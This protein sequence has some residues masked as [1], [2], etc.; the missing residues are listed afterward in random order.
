M[1]EKT[2]SSYGMLPRR[3]A[4]PDPQDLSAPIVVGEKSAPKNS[5][6]FDLELLDQQLAQPDSELAASLPP[7][8][9]SCE[10]CFWTLTAASSDSLLSLSS[11][12]SMAL[13]S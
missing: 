6:M 13:E 11:E 3:F 8:Q 5:L 4:P 1:F 10:A 9:S 7:W 2:A 12:T